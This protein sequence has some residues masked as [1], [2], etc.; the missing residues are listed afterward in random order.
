MLH[1]VSLDTIIVSL[2]T[3]YRL[4]RYGMTLYFNKIQYDTRYVIVRYDMI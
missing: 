4:S 2:D 3:I 1:I